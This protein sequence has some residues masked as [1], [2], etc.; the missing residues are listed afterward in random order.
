MTTPSLNLAE[1]SKPFLGYLEGWYGGLG[2]Q[3]L[4][5]LIAGR[6]EKV[7]IISIDVINGFCKAGPL[8][9]ERV[10]RIA[11][12][13]AALFERA[14]ALGVRHFAL[15]QDTHAPDSPEFQV[16]P[17]HCIVGTE[18]SEAVDELKALPFY[19]EIAIFPKGSI[20]SHIGT[21]LG[22][23]VDTIP[24]LDTFIVVGDCSD[25]CAYQ[26]AMHLRLEAN[27]LGIERTVV[28]PADIVDTFD[29]PVA[30]ASELGI[31]AHDADLHHVL[32]LHHMASN[33]VKVVARLD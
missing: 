25:L 20:N 10:G 22:M 2:P 29:T 27:A 18:E 23:W 16:Y 19:S 28:V 1:R 3:S 5:E 33:G 15:T 8:A 11:Q 9:S 13:I 6:P 32:F 12:P 31:Y 21:S 24:E 4:E 26:A 17:P 7:A 14:Y 30:T